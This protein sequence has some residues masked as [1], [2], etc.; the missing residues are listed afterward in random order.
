MARKEQVDF[1]GRGDGR[2]YGARRKRLRWLTKC[3]NR[4]SI[5]AATA[6]ATAAARSQCRH[7]E[8]GKF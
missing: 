8:K 1:A 4:L 3:I 2:G 6:T 5:I 7:K